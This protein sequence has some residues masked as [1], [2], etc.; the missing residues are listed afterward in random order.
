M[1]FDPS[2]PYL[3]LP[4]LPP[5]VE[6]E[7]RAVL[8]A[9]IAARAAVAELKAAGRLIPNQG[10]LINTIPLLEAQASSEIE[11]IVTTTDQMFLFDG[12]S[13]GE[14]DPA[15]KEALRYRTALWEG[16][17]ALR[18]RPLS[19]NTAVQ[20]CR[21]IKGVDMDVRRTPGTTL[22]NDRTREVIYTPPEGE[23]L[24]REKL[25]NWEQWMHGALPGSDEIDPLV[26]MAIAHYQ[27]EA[28]HPFTDGNGRTG[29]IINLLYLVE[30]KL[31]DIPILYLSRHILRHRSEYYSGLQSVTATGAWEP[32]L[33]YMLHSVTETA[34]WTMDKILAVR[35]LLEE[36]TER[37]RREAGPIYSRELAELIFVR[38]Y[39]RISHIVEAG[40]AKR[41]TASAYLKHLTDI[42]ILREHKVGREKVF[43]NPAFIELLKRD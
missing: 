14:A 27:F 23:A 2:R 9:C 15:T 12:V 18:A 21:A 33:L 25:A 35:T 30:Q 43:L 22:T 41:Q 37:M 34:R 3:D 1:P 10:V 5:S 36:T 6:L 28:I 26:R 8:K 42:G 39:C 4:A 32:W 11:N 13:E 31:L 29:R 40:L 7:T 38:P 16:F 17:E 24:L 19:T 20:I